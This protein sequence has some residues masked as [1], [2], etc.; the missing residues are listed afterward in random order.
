MVE[1]NF[2]RLIRH[3]VEIL[4]ERI[5]LLLGNWNVKKCGETRSFLLY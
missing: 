2:Y 4:G 5:E 3:V 1:L